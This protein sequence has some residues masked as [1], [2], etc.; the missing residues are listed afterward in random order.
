MAA[1]A[2]Q[3]AQNRQGAPGPVYAQGNAQHLV[4]QQQQERIRALE[5]DL[6]QQRIQAAQA[7]QGYENQLLAIG[8]ERQVLIDRLA[9]L[10]R[11]IAEKDRLLGGLRNE[12]QALQRKQEQDAVQIAH[13]A[14]Q[15]AHGLREIAL[16]SAQVQ[17]GR[18]ENQLLRGQLQVVNGHIEQLRAQNNQLAAEVRDLAKMHRETLAALQQ[19]PAQ[20]TSFIEDVTSWAGGILKRAFDGRPPSAYNPKMQ[21]EL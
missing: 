3:A 12:V 21:G 5:L 18:E 8:Q 7:A 2:Q 11:Q 14:A 4:I 13:D 9:L 20:E 16:L 19:K 1:A 15:I 6:R 17:Q 10:D